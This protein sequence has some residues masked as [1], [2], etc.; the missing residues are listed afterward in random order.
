MSNLYQKSKVYYTVR[1]EIVQS[2]N[3]GAT[4]FDAVGWPVEEGGEP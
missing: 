3:N 2:N 1:L 4:V